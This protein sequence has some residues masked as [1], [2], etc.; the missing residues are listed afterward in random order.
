MNEFVSVSGQKL[1]GDVRN[2]AVIGFGKTGKALLNFLMAKNIGRQLFLFNDDVI[3]DEKEK[4]SFQQNGV[5]FLEGEKSFTRLQEMDLMVISPGVDG[6]NSRFEALRKSGQKI[7]SEIEF[8]SYFI[9]SKI[10]AVTGTNGKSTTVSLIH[11]ILSSGGLPAVL[12]GNI[13]NPLIAEVMGLNP[14]SV[15]ILE[16]SSFQLEE[17]VHFRPDIG[18]L[19]NVTPD[20]L[21][22]Y[23]DM[24]AYLSTKIKIGQNQNRDDFLIYNNDDSWLREHID[25]R[26]Q[27]IGFSITQK[28][29]KGYFIENNQVIDSLRPKSEKI[30][31]DNNPLP[32]IHNLENVL[33]SVIVCRLLG[34][35]VKKIETGMQGFKGLPHRA[36]VLGK[37]GRVEFINDSK[38]TNVDATL[39]VMT[40]FN[41]GVVLILG[42]KDK[43]GDFQILEAPIKQRT[44]RVLL[45]GSAASRIYSELASVKAKMHMVR[46]LR[47]AVREGFNTLKQHGGTVLLA[48]GCAS[49]DMFDNFEHRGECF[50]KEFLTLKRE[51][52]NG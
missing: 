40:S 21:D 7:I 17:I 30:S 27:L 50:K 39:K 45:V 36:E 20:H 43:G 1:L 33:S 22:R 24:A 6:R 52:E 48:P 18:V 13:G 29:E 46:D 25:S 47:E 10:I 26:A 5:E 14:E 38:A 51:V 28:L 19:L 9:P 37:I 11:H 3:R 32:G 8:A 44:S 16:V 23:S 42:G 2:I 35:S 34:L 31:L 12:A 15:V 4:Q 49:F 41:S